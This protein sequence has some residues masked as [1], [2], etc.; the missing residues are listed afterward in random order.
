M[1]Q[2]VFLLLNLLLYYPSPAVIYCTQDIFVEELQAPMPDDWEL[3][4]DKNGVKIYTK[5]T[6][7][8][9][10]KTYKGEAVFNISL[11]RIYSIL[12][13]VENYDK[14]VYETPESTL[15]SST[16]DVEYT[17]YSV[18]SMPWPFDNRDMVTRIIVKKEGE[19]IRLETNL[20][21]GIVEPKEGLV[22]ITAYKEVT[23]ISKTGDGQVRMIMEGY[24]E[25]GGSLPAWLVNMFLSEGPYES[26][27][28]LRELYE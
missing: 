2:L 9:K 24:F 11:E 6:E 7:G 18:V 16:K 17:Y 8:S 1:K 25:P 5:P 3:V 15:L 12:T 22:R 23:T 27:M 19:T 13:D 10:Y 21:E 20:V 4:L 28:K 26:L 14:W